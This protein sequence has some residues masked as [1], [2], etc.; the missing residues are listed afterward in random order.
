MLVT[1]T[2]LPTIVMALALS[3][4]AGDTPYPVMSA[5]HKKCAETAP[6]GEGYRDC[7]QLG[8]ERAVIGLHPHDTD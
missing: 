1:K 2:T 8:L 6:P 5:V 4:C 3:A 7:T